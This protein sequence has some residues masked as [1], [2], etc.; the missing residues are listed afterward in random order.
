MRCAS[1]PPKRTSQ[2]NTHSDELLE[3]ETQGVNLIPQIP[4]RVL[5]WKRAQRQHAYLREDV[6]EDKFSKLFGRVM[7][8]IALS[9]TKVKR[10]I[11]SRLYECKGWLTYDLS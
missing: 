8:E 2:K 11:V 7:M 9:E 10:V 4:R 5:A 3:S 6:H 1:L